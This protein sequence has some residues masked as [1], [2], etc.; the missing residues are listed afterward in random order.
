M[1]KLAIH[2]TSIFLNGQGVL[3]IGASGAGKSSLALELIE[4]GG[5]LIS[6]DI[7]YLTEKDGKLWALCDEKW[8]GY[9][10]V[11][12]LGIIQNIPFKA[13]SEINYVIEL[14]E[15]KTQRIP[16]KISKKMYCGLTVPMFKIY[17]DEKFLPTLV[18]I[19][20]KIVSKEVSLMSFDEN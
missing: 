20:G 15:E 10:E 2:A 4:Q 16:E 8:Q 3:I 5:V 12:G 13:L 18:K 14:V 9:I 7:T 11:R 19:A 1:T 6:D 17:K